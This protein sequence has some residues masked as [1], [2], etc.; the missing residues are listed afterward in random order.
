MDSDDQQRRV[1][2]MNEL[3]AM[4]EGKL[5]RTSIYEAVRRG[6]IPSLK[7]GSRY[8]IPA[9]ALDALLSGIPDEPAAVAS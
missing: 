8:L 7:I 1:Y 4:L 3:V 5:G 2:T 6:D 9:K